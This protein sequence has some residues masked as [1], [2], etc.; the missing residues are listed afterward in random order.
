[1]SEEEFSEFIRGRIGDT[2]F[3]ERCRECLDTFDEE[4]TGNH[5]KE[6]LNDY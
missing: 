4:H 6:K 2:D 3:A 5:S 1:L